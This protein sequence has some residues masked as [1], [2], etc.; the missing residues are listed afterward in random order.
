MLFYILGSVKTVKKLLIS[1]AIS[2]IHNEYNMPQ[3]YNK[4]HNVEHR[5]V[6]AVVPHIFQLGRL[7]N[8]HCALFCFL[9]FQPQ[10]FKKA[11]ENLLLQ[12]LRVLGV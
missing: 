9:S 4:L 2:Y 1:I 5:I 11:E 8:M 6:V 12:A 10:I 3:V 7:N